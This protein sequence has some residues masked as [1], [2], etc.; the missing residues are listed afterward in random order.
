MLLHQLRLPQ[1]QLAH[2]ILRHLVLVRE[3]GNE[4]QKGID[5]TSIFQAEGKEFYESA[6][7]GSTR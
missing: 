2:T 7:P 1:Y 3:L 5:A 6:H 4:E